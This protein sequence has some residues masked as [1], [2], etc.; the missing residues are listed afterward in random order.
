MSLTEELNK[1]EYQSGSYAERFALLKSKTVP[2][3]GQLK[4]G[5]L[6]HLETMIV[7]GLWRDKVAALKKAAYLVLDDVNAAPEAKALAFKKAQVAAGFHEA[8]A[9]SKLARKEEPPVGHSINLADDKINEF[10]TGAQHPAI[11]LLTP[12]EVARLKELA[13]WDKPLFPDVKIVD[14]VAHFAPELLDGQWHELEPTHNRAFTVTLTQPLP[15]PASIIVQYQEIYDGWESAW[16]H[17]TAL[18]VHEQGI[19]RADTPYNGYERRLR[20]RCEYALVGTV[21]VL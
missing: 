16:K 9:E 7:D 2:T 10:F 17:A 5:N 11:A 6:K 20:W 13:T 21:A 14:V 12:A 15:E 4:T 3:L 8:L 1:P 18:T 19:Y